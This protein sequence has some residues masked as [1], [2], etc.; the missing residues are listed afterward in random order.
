MSDWYTVRLS[1]WH[2]VR[3]SDWHNVRLSDWYTVRLS[4]WNTVRLSDWYIVRLSDWYNVRLIYCQTD[5]LIYCQT[6]LLSHCQ[7]F[8]LSNY[9]LSY[10]NTNCVKLGLKNFKNGIG[11]KSSGP[12]NWCRDVL[13]SSRSW[14]GW[15]LQGEEAVSGYGPGINL[16]PKNVHFGKMYFKEQTSNAQNFRLITKM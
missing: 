12:K 7:T 5:R 9:L 8:I 11:T 15:V 16:G 1:D 13:K 14:L 2:N 4:D 10:Y 6:D 3:L